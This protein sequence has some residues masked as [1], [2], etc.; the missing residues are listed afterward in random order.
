MKRTVP[1]PEPPDPGFNCWSRLPHKISCQW[2]REILLPDVYCTK[3]H[4]SSVNE[5]CY[6]D[7]SLSTGQEIGCTI[8]STDFYSNYEIRL[9]SDGEELARIEDFDIGKYLVIEEPPR[10]FAAS[11]ID[12]RVRLEWSNSG[13]HWLNILYGDQLVLELLYKPYLQVAGLTRRFI[14]YE[15]DLQGVIMLNDIPNSEVLEL[16]I[17]VRKDDSIRKEWSPCSKPVILMPVSQPT[18]LPPTLAPE[19]CEKFNLCGPRN[20]TK[21][22]MENDLAM[23]TSSI[24]VVGSIVFVI[25]IIKSSWKKIHMWLLPPIPEPII[26]IH[27]TQRDEP[28]VEETRLLSVENETRLSSRTEACLR[29]AESVDSGIAAAPS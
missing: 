15:K 11:R 19:D 6:L 18:T 21:N 8:N 7:P 20:G 4:D 29:T 27:E 16:C 23:L 3:T 25:I 2:S 14:G 13:N 10:D 1:D 26:V 5:R 9:S 17:R 28:D 24:I 12:G 22:D